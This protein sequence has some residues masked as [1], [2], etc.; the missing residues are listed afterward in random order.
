M[1][2]FRVYCW[3][4]TAA[5]VAMLVV[6]LAEVGDPPPLSTFLFWICLIATVELLP[7]TL[8]QG[9]EV[10]MGFP[11][12]LAL[13]LLF[14]PWVGMVI[15]GIGAMDVREFR[16]E[17]PPH[18]IAF[19]RSQTMIS[20]G[21][22]SAV[23]SLYGRTLT[24]ESIRPSIILAIALA[25]TANTGANLSLVVGALHYD[26]AIPSTQALRALLPDP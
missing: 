14:S 16:R 18:R 6:S 7:M 2:R 21:L 22:A 5:A 8:A 23:F 25:A 4:V 11:L 13:A 12:H 1:N 19:N 17:L 9:A 15:S 24:T 26:E 20:V 10:T 3:A